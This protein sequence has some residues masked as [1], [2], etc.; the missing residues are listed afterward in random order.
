[1]QPADIETNTFKD[2]LFENKGLLSVTFLNLESWISR[3]INPATNL[4]V[5]FQL[6]ANFRTWA[7]V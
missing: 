5:S 6:K 4:N 7:H 1:M 2:K 3:N